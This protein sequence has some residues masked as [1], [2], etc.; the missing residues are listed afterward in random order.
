MLSISQRTA[1]RH[2]LTLDNCVAWLTALLQNYDGKEFP[3]N[4][5]LAEAGIRAILHAK[6]G[7][8]IE[9]FPSRLCFLVGWQSGCK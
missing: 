1:E 7:C 8:N 3:R 2:G 5:V 9:V 6:G 4:E